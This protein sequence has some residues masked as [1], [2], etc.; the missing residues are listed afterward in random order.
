MKMGLQIALVILSLIPLYFGVTG[1]LLGV[2]TYMPEG[3]YPASIDNQ[4]RYLGG[5]YL[6]VAIMLWRIIPAI[7]KHGT[8]LAIVLGVVFIGALARVLSI[9][10]LESPPPIMISAMI[11]EFVL[12]LLLVWQRV[13][14][15]S[16]A[17]QS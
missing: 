7:E 1:M 9:F 10:T 4:F 14:A 16:A 3:G 13:V 11:V 15:Q 17:T 5:I 8:T 6:L 2:S 12:P